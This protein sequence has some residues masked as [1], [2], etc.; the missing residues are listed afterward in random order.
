MPNHRCHPVCVHVFLKRTETPSAR[1]QIDAGGQI[2]LA[3]KLREWFSCVHL[4]GNSVMG[5]YIRS[6]FAENVIGGK[7]SQQSSYSAILDGA[8]N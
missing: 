1:Q 5:E 7:E 4:N 8:H 6:H 2:S 3:L